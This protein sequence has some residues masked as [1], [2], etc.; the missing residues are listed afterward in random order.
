MEE[1]L[2][3]KNEEE[4]MEK[5]DLE[6]DNDSLIDVNVGDKSIKEGIQKDDD[7]DNEEENEEEV[8][9][10]DDEDNEEEDEEV[11][12]NK[13][14]EI[15]KVVE[16]EVIDLNVEKIDEDE[17]ETKLTQRKLRNNNDN[18]EDN[19]IE[20]EMMEINFKKKEK[21]KIEEIQGEE[22]EEGYR[23]KTN[24][25]KYF[26]VPKRQEA[27]KIFTNPLNW[28]ITE[29]L[30]AT[31]V[32]NVVFLFLPNSQIILPF[33]FLFWRFCYNVGLG[34][35]LKKQSETSL[36]T[37]IYEALSK[38]PEINKILNRVIKSCIIIE[39]DQDEE[40]LLNELPVEFKAWCSFR[41][42]IDIILGHDVGSYICFCLAFIQCP[43]FDN[44]MYDVF[45][46][47]V[48]I[49]LIVLT[50]WAKMDAYRV[51]KDF[52][53]YWGDFFF[54]I[55][56]NLTF[57]RVFAMF[58]HPMYTVGYSAFYGTAIICRSYTVLYVSIIAHAL[59][60][61]FLI[62]VENPHIEKTYG[63]EIA[64]DYEA[65]KVLTESGYLRRDLIL[66]KNFSIFRS[67]DLF[68]VI[69]VINFFLQFFYNLPGWF[70]IMQC[71][72]WKI[73]TSASLGYILINQSKDKDFF[74]NI[75]YTK[76]KID[77]FENWKRVLNCFMTINWAVF[78]VCSLHYMTF[79]TDLYGF[80]NWMV[81][82]V[83]GLLLI[84]LNIWSAVSQY[85]TLGSF[86]WFYGDFFIDNIASK[87]YYTGIY[88]YLNNPEL[89]TGC[90]GYFGF[91]IMSRS[92]ESFAIALTYQI[93]TFLF[94]EIVEK[95]HMA[96]LYGDK[97]RE[98]SGIA[99]AFQEILKESVNRSNNEKFKSQISKIQKKTKKSASSLL[100]EAEKLVDILKHVDH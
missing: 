78:I 93:I 66:F 28:T 4:I 24:N 15:K 68:M 29:W 64:R 6:S 22:N 9:N 75:S 47:L 17:K 95:P 74:Y 73:S 45:L 27:V 26:K 90:A 30:Q 13:E 71:L 88:R 58:P 76:N 38:I 70:Y 39:K 94:Q 62:F 14:E 82:V 20:E 5:E 7:D 59:Q 3:E 35:L 56:Q 50:L 31:L 91:A 1:I 41:G 19:E 55:E 16:N 36:V 69:I 18:D 49:G 83:I 80:Y 98:K 33:I 86:G 23:G 61:I 43:S 48:G 97:V 54:L 34:Y 42:F 92:W 72:V 37:Q 2:E 65:E 44:I 53:W 96:R 77:T 63:G 84:A 40:E 79:P 52:A 67:S 10:K 11:V 89:V 99:T 32:F 57:D 8:E 100:Q 25:G 60:F 51:V 85:D 87:L 81:Y 12:D 21:I 46:Y